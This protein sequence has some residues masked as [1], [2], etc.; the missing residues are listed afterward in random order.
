[1]AKASRKL[2]LAL[3]TI[4]V[5]L[6][7]LVAGTYALFSREFTSTNHLVAGNLNI[8]LTRTRLETKT[9]GAE[10][11]LVTSTNADE[12]DF[13]NADG[14]N[15]FDLKDGAVI[16]PGCEFTA[17]LKLTNE[18][19][20]A[21]SYW[22]E[23]VVTDSSQ[24]EALAQQLKVK[25]TAADGT[26]TQSGSVSTGFSIGSETDGIG[27]VIVGE[28]A[29]FS[30]SVEFPDLDENNDARDQSVKFDIVIHAIQVTTP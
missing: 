5:C 30:V 28:S 27:T 17:D 25:L 7:L 29:Q 6:A 26:K 2:L 23:V 16:A 8:K 9:L 20:V 18:G 4:A 12:K 22:L 14:E 1:M 19:S 11:Y 24:G 15:I 21:F 13:T 3:L 10:G